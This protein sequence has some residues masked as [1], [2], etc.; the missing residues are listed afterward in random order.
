MDQKEKYIRKITWVG[1][2][3]NL[4]LA[5][6]KLAA[7]ILG[8]S[9]AVVADAIHSLSDST[10]D[11]AVIVGSHYWSKPPDTDHPYGHQRIETL[12]TLFIGV[13]LLCA[14]VGIGWDA[15][16][17]LHREQS[18]P[19]GAIAFWAAALSIVSK[20]VA[21]RWTNMAGIRVKSAALMANAWHHRL[22]AFSSVPVLLAVGGILLFPSWTFLDQVGASIVSIFIIQAAVKIIWPGLKE[23]IDTGAPREVCE[24][25]KEIVQR[26][27][28]VI[29]VHKI[30]TR[31]VGMSLQVD[32]HIV[33]DSSITVL[34]G[35]NIAREV[36]ERLLSDGPDVLDVIIHTE[37][38]E[39][40]IAED[41]CP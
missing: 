2:V 7:G 5:A 19:P 40:A 18:A 11:I 20:E 9:Q 13:I 39:E 33:V 32:L 10:T 25:I 1:M 38:L 6:V 21:Y 28:N 41:P 15:V 29:Q 12:V 31:Y 35:H 34:E 30:R 17:S 22:D 27:A 3:L 26:H 14:G 24:H 16:L 23:F 37:P 8:N 36:K 4:A